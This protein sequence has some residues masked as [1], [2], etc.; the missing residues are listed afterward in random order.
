MLATATAAATRSLENVEDD[1]DEW[2]GC[3]GPFETTPYAGTRKH[4]QTPRG[5]RASHRGP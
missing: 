1:E 5:G 3:K 4:S 2:E